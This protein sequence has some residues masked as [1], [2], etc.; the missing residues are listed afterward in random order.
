MV[1]SLKNQII[2][3]VKRH[4]ILRSRDLDESGIPR[5]YL[6]RLVEEGVLANPGRGLYVLADA[7]PSVH[8]SLIEAC[9]RVPHGVICLLSALQYHGLTT[10]APFEVWLA[11]GAS[12]RR[13][14]V[15]YPPL[16]IVRYNH[17][18]LTTGVMEQR[19]NGARIKVYSP[20]KTVADCFKYR[21]KIGLEVALEALRDSWRKRRATMDEIHRAAEVCR[22]GRVI[23]PYLESLV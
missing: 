9:V 11:I 3:Q 1:Q 8:Q 18:A 6:R 16:R 15:D 23:R 20:A 10:Q 22:V 21:N 13:P 7:R 2:Q 4:G 17:A 19:V 14:K 5:A 12:A